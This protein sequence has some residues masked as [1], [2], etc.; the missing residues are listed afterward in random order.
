M[1]CYENRN[2][3]VAAY[4]VDAKRFL[5]PR[6]G[7]GDGSG[8]RAG[9]YALAEFDP[10]EIREELER[11]GVT[12]VFVYV[13]VSPSWVDG[14]IVDR[15]T[16]AAKFAHMASQVRRAAKAWRAVPVARLNDGTDWSDI[17][18]SR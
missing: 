15:G 2:G 18:G 1:I 17:Y 9:G 12:E 11:R 8:I 6:D 7:N 3:L 4:D 16:R 5:D 14:R 13:G 10:E